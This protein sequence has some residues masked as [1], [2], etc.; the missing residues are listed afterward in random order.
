MPKLKKIHKTFILQHLAMF[1]TPQEVAA[2]VKEEFG[3]EIDRRHVFYYDAEM[4]FDLPKAWRSLFET[5][6][7][8]FLAEISAIPIANKAYRLREL[9]RMYQNHKSSR[10]QNPVEMRAILEQAAKESGDAYTNRRELTSKDG[11]P[12]EL[13]SVVILP[14][15]REI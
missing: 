14:N 4:N 3:I 7:D 10:L 13:N 1:S 5:T 9:N 8:R 11:T 15:D 12:L 2:L 6:R